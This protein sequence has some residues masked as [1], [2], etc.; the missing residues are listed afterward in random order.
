MAKISN[1]HFEIYNLTTCT[2]LMG[3]KFR[4]G[5]VHIEYDR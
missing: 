4:I 2:V 3:Q 1:S 5:Y